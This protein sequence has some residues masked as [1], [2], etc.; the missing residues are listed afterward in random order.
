MNLDVLTNPVVRAAAAD[1]HD[2]YRRM[3]ATDGSARL[4]I[5][6]LREVHHEVRLEDDDTTYFKAAGRTSENP[7]SAAPFN[8]QIARS[9]EILRTQIWL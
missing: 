4:S 2:T 6:T 5:L 8:P 7:R 9:L 3:E 1:L